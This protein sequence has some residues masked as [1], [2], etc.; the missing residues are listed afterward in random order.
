[1]TRFF[2]N[3]MLWIGTGITILIAGIFTFA[4]MG[5]TV[6]PTPKKLPLAFVVEDEGVKLPNGEQLNLSEVLIEELQRRDTLEVDWITIPSEEEALEAMDNKKVYATIVLPQQLSRDIFSILT[7]TPSKPTSTI[8]INEG[9][10]QAGANVAAQITNGVLA[11]FNQQV[12]AQLLFQMEEMKIPLS[13]DLAKLVLN[14]ISI[15]IQEINTIPANNANGNTPALFSQL[16]WILTFTSS[17]ILFTLLS[18]SSEGKWTL[19]SF[20]SQIISGFLYVTLICGVILLLAVNVLDVHVADQGNLFILMV[21]VGLCFFFIQNA[22][23]NW[24]GYP[25]A[26]LI[27]LLFFFSNPILM[28]APEMLPD[29]TRDYLYSWV[30]FRF[31]LEHFKDILFFEKGIFEN[32]VGTIGVMGFISFLLMGLAIFKPKS[33]RE[34]MLEDDKNP[35]TPL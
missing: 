13:I 26:S 28:I 35:A 8:I 31:S 5:S 1:M 17:M 4:F 10:N 24:I 32:G 2:T 23:L 16:L 34:K 9:M 25:A 15:E 30:P 7:N 27:I 3:K 33:K 11:N 22:L 29:V 19:K 14:P 18:K 21:F 6:N 12:Q 20:V